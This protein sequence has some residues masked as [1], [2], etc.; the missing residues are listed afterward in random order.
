SF[1]DGGVRIPASTHIYALDST[2]A[3]VTTNFPPTV[4]PW[5]NPGVPTASDVVTVTALVNDREDAIV[6]V[7]LGYALNGAAQAPVMMTPTANPNEWAA[8][9]PAQPNGTRV[10][11]TVT[12]MAGADTTAWASGY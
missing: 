6:S 3:G 9:I 12:A 5:I 11:Y 1:E 4:I 8:T 10:D 2:G 7:T